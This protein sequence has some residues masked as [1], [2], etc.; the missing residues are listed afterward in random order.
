MNMDLRV[1]NYERMIY[2]HMLSLG[3]KYD[4][5]DFLQI[6]RLAVYKGLQTADNN[7]TINE[8]SLIYGLVRNRLIDEIRRRQKYRYE[9][10]NETQSTEE[11]YY[12]D[13]CYREWM[14]VLSNILNPMEYKCLELILEGHTQS[15]VAF[16][17]ARSPS[18]VKQY[19]RS[20]RAK[21]AEHFY[22]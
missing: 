15:E 19:K 9:V 12:D 7:D 14:H 3:I 17:L 10:L 2:K 11:C 4:W 18:M 16:L 21:A 6:G 1:L 22:K 20:I 5:E 13:T 8:A